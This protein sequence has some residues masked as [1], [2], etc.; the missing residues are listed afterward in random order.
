MRHI[1]VLAN[2]L[3]FLIV[4]FVFAKNNLKINN[5]LQYSRFALFATSMLA[6]VGTSVYNTILSYKGVIVS[7]V[8]SIVMFIY[9]IYLAFYIGNMVVP[10]THSFEFENT[11]NISLIN[12]S[13]IIVLGLL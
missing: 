11:I 13:P 1:I 9:Q 6:V 4:L 8:F 5:L 2:S 10:P 12:I 7:L 3:L